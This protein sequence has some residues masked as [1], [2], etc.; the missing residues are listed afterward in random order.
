MRHVWQKSYSNKT[1]NDRAPLLYSKQTFSFQAQYAMTNRTEQLK[2]AKL[3]FGLKM[4]LIAVL[5]AGLIW[6]NLAVGEVDPPG[7]L[8]VIDVFGELSVACLVL[9]WIVLI[10]QTRLNKNI[11]RYLFTGFLLIYIGFLQDTLEE[12]VDFADGSLWNN[13]L[14]DIPIPIGAVLVSIGFYC[15]STRQTDLRR[16]TERKKAIYKSLSLTDELTGVGNKRALL[17]YLKE[18]IVDV[19]EG[20]QP[21]AVMMLDLDYF[22]Q[23]NDSYGHS[24]GDEVLA[25]FGSLLN[26]CIR[27]SDSAFRFGG[28]EFTVVM[29]DTSADE[30]Y[31]VAER[32]RLQALSKTFSFGS[33]PAGIQVSVSIG[34]AVL[35][36]FEDTS[37]L[38]NRADTLLYEAK[39][40]GR[41]RTVGDWMLSQA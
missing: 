30:A 17:M 15:W 13:V 8:N 12:F 4:L 22:K 35:D 28:E 14:E 20:R 1:N 34:V 16:K 41:N 39:D 25:Y 36:R 11:E 5:S 7:E 19:K 21:L 10:L 27:A 23:I 40:Q 26:N 32:I 29:P 37:N 3:T 33:L 31:I 2:K 24:A 9:V 18:F 38:L 6:F